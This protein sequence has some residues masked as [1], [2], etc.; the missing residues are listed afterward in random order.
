MLYQLSYWPIHEVRSEKPDFEFLASPFQRDPLLAFF[1]RRVLPAEPAVLVE[2]E[3]FRAL[4][5]I[6]GRAVVAT[7]TFAARERDDFAH[8]PYLTRHAAARV[9][10][11]RP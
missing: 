11:R 6:L 9:T 2:L 3:P 8:E 7:F 1:V 5:A 10:P 4:P